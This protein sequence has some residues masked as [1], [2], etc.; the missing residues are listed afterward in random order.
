[1]MSFI[2]PL[3]LAR[4]VPERSPLSFLQREIEEKLARDCLSARPRPSDECGYTNILLPAS[5]AQGEELDQRT[6]VKPNVVSR[7]GSACVRLNGCRKDNR[8]SKPCARLFRFFEIAGFPDLERNVSLSSFL[9]LAP[10]PGP[11]QASSLPLMSFPLRH[12]AYIR[13][14]SFDCWAK[15]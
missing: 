3:H 8:G 9:G 15:I 4:K 13:F 7:A 2:L 1:M 14:F 6:T 10:S 11:L 5:A 12:L